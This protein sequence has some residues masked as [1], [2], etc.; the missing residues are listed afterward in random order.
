MVN[1]N[2]DDLVSLVGNEYSLPK[3]IPSKKVGFADLSH[4]HC[5]KSNRYHVSIQQLYPYLQPTIVQRL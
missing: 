3:G 2:P 5:A 4:L 1:L